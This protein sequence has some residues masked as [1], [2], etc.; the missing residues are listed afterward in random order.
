MGTRAASW[1]GAPA[2]GSG[3]G[4]GGKASLLQPP[5]SLALVAPIY[6][7]FEPHIGP[8][9]PEA[10]RGTHGSAACRT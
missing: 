5:R 6:C 4:G 7:C 2:G 1:S 9:A 8:T 3:G 10:A